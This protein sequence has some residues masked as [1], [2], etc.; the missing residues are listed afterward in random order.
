MDN[1]VQV[2]KGAIEVSRDDV[3][4][5]PW[6]PNEMD[7]REMA[8]LVEQIQD[9]GFDEPVIVVP[10]P[11]KPGKYRIVNGEHRWK[12]AGILHLEKIPVVVKENWTDE[13]VKIHSVRRNVVRGKLNDEKFTKLVRDL[14][15][16]DQ[17]LDD[18]CR[19]MA[20]EERQFWKHVIQEKERSKEVDEVLKETKRELEMVED[21]SL[22]LNE[23]LGKFGDTV[24]N[25]FIFFMYKGKM[26]FMV[27]AKTD[28]ADA[29]AEMVAHLKER[30]EDAND[31]L[32]KSIRAALENR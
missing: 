31:F 24:P 10:H 4:P 7:D 32:A 12:A 11:E 27:R 13:D 17:K 15:G 26:H 5:N 22:V 30:G 16:S 3:E 8:S 23:I 21:L 25:N 28:L 19:R 9:T 29:V 6:N 14:A 18:V 1:D 2:W 20:M